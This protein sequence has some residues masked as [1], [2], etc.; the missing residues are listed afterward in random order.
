MRTAAPH[1]FFISGGSASHAELTRGTCW[2]WA[3]R[4]RLQDRGRAPQKESVW[5][6]LPHLLFLHSQRLHKEQAEQ[7]DKQAQI[8]PQDTQRSEISK[9]VIWRL[10]IRLL[11]CVMHMLKLNSSPC[12]Q[13]FWILSFLC[14]F[15][16]NTIAS[17]RWRASTVNK[18]VPRS[19]LPV[20]QNERIR[21]DGGIFPRH[22]ANLWRCA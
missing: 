11:F 3:H 4:I 6:P 16:D 13:P 15:Q 18:Y 20:R 12:T 1:P 5:L 10:G 7:E 22:N 21:H 19:K 9:R 2:V 8:Q 14:P 17:K